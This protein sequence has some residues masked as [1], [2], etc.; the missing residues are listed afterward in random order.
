MRV[1]FQH[2]RVWLAIRSMGLTVWLLPTKFLK[3]RYLFAVQLS[4]DII[5]EELDEL[6]KDETSKEY[7]FQNE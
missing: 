3:E 7:E 6:T 5:Q 2:F 4:A 1:M